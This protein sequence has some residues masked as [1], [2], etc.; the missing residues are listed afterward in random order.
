LNK[1]AKTVFYMLLFIMFCYFQRRRRIDNIQKFQSM[2]L[3][4]KNKR[5]I[6]DKEIER[7]RLAHRWFLIDTTILIIFM[8]EKVL[9]HFSSMVKSHSSSLLLIYKQ[10]IGRGDWTGLEYIKTLS[11]LSSTRDY[12]ILLYMIDI[13]KK[14]LNL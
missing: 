12:R 14:T 7:N 9:S 11:D 4:W 2:V 10:T 8:L 6:E 3:N 13:I 1:S 5:K